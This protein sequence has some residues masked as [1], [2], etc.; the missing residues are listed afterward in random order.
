MAR[1]LNPRMRHPEEQAAG[2]QLTA[3]QIQAV[4]VDILREI[5]R[6]CDENHIEYC[7]IGG[8][9]L[10]IARH[11]GGF[12][13]WDDDLDIAV[14]AGD[15]PRFVAAMQTLPGHLVLRL[16]SRAIC[17]AY[18]ILDA[19]TRVWGGAHH[20]GSV[21]VDVLPM[22]HWRSL[23]WK[24]L[25]DFVGW[26]SRMARVPV[27][28]APLRTSAKALVCAVGIPRLAAWFGGEVLYKFFRR[29]DLAC[30]EARQ[31]VVTGGFGRPWVGRYPHDVIYPLRKASFCGVSLNVPSDLHRFL[32]LRYGP[33]YLALPPPQSRWT[34]FEGAVWTGTT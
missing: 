30:R 5:V 15:M 14:W 34:H 28:G 33:D 21:F 7:L 8:G 20:P 13:P 26:L 16:K 3:P 27:G 29:A 1:T 23:A 32:T 17:P 22:M 31:G 10:G 4:L 11:D 18:E 24:R 9:C 6:L 12:V 25:D 19:R 2:S